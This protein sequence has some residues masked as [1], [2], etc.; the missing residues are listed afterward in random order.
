[1][2]DEIAYVMINDILGTLDDFG[3][4]IAGAMRGNSCWEIIFRKLRNR[5][6]FYPYVSNN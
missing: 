2:L 1:M 6:N 4:E 5:I 3:F